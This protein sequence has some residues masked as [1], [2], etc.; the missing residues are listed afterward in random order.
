MTDTQTTTS[1]ADLDAQTHQAYLDSGENKAAA[2]RALGVSASTVANRVKRHQARHD[3]DTLADSRA[4]DAA[5]AEQDTEYAADS[6]QP[7]TEQAA[8]TEVAENVTVIRPDAIDEYVAQVNAEAAAA[9]AAGLDTY[10]GPVCPKCDAVAFA[11]KGGH[12]VGCDYGTVASA[13]AHVEASDQDV[14][15]GGSQERIAELAEHAHDDHASEAEA[16][17]PAPAESESEKVRYCVKCGFDFK[18][19]QKRQ[20][21]QSDKACQRRQAEKTAAAA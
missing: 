18:R 3:Q 5:Q 10:Q 20:T 16:E 11:F 7:E 2:A 4:L 13:A 12:Q 9:E 14:P 19:P 15:D 17:A 8:V 21:C 1:Q 6:E